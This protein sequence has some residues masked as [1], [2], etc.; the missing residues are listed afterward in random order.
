MLFVSFAAGVLLATTF[1]ELLPEAIERAQ[2]ATGNVFIATLVAMAAFF[3]LERLL[4]GFHEHHEHERHEHERRAVTSGYLILIGDSV[5]NFIDG[6]VIAAT[7]LVNPALGVATTAGGRRAR[8]PAGDRRLRHPAAQPVPAAAAA[9]L[10]N[11]ASGLVRGAR[12]A[13]VLLVRGP[14]R[15]AICRGS[16]PPPPACSSTSPPPT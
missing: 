11:F 15:S 13:L 6:V 12:G 9:L 5:H 14:G 2:S 1:L 10:L 3:V 8:D 16:W 7:F 4:H